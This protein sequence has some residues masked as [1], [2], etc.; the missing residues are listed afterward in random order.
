MKPA[1]L[2]R[3]FARLFSAICSQDSRMKHFWTT[4][5]RR[6]HPS[7]L[8]LVGKMSGGIGA[9][10]FNL[11][12]RTRG[13]SRSQ[14][15]LPALL[16]SLLIAVNVH[17]AIPPAEKLLPVDTLLVLCVPDAAAMATT[18]KRSPQNQFW[19][20]PAMKPFRDK[21]MTKWKEEFLEPLE[22]DLGVKLADYTSLLQGQLVFAIS[23]NGWQGAGAAQPATLLLLDAK[24]RS[25]QLKTNLT[26]LRKK[27]S[28]AGK[29]VR[30]EKIRDVEF[31][32][33]TLSSNDLP[34][35][36]KRFFPQKQEI[37]E[38]GREP[39]KPS[40]ERNELI[41]GQYESLLILG[42]ALPPVENV[43]AHLTGGN[44]PALADEPA[45]ERDRL[46]LLRETG[47]YLWCN[48]QR[49][50]DV[51]AK[52]PR[53]EPNPQAPTPMPLPDFH[54][55]FE[56]LG[57]G[58]LKTLAFTFREQTAGTTTELFIGVPET[59]RKGLFKLL[60]PEAKES[61]PPPFVPA[62][63]VKFQ[64][65]RLDGQKTLATLEK[66]LGEA[67]PQ[68]LSTWNFLIQSGEIAVRESNPDYDLRKNLFGNLGDDLIRYEKPPR[69]KSPTELASPPSLF[70]IGSPNADALCRALAGVLVIRSA[71]ALTPKTREFLGR[72][73][74]SISIPAT[75]QSGPKT[76]SYT[77]SG[78]YVAFSTDA[79]ILEE[80]IRSAESPAR[81][82]KETAGFADAVER[83][84]GPGTG[85]F[86]YENQAESMRATFERFKNA[87][88]SADRGPAADAL[89]LASALPF[90]S[91]EKSFRDWMDFSLLPEFDKVARYFHMTVWAGSASTEGISFK[92]FTPTPPASK[93]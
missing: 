75:G 4:L 39:E 37:Q 66:T 3:V 86:S 77:A 18:L 62:D 7:V 44:A 90:A 65:W 69:G 35:T 15:W 40:A 72:R 52:L 26:T 71:E 13:S 55:L 50:L 85:M 22:R 17:A 10:H 32:M 29:A 70:A 8:P 87:P 23:Q 16:L 12:R 43:V 76:L 33:V 56:G 81:P 47:G 5:G 73:I 6:S 20:D 78:G 19:N 49:F 84:G 63:A 34:A 11:T 59:T 24:S 67:L 46:A 60:T 58:G 36:I 41:I 79:P 83:V 92:F 93:P 51:I 2:I 28:D 9:K 1:L 42:T 68:F 48:A 53:P 54:K 88:N 14:A 30:L 91:P 31:A 61:G 82:L 38:L 45:Y 27:W 21:F 89:P 64:R 74:Y 57:F 80:F 25:D